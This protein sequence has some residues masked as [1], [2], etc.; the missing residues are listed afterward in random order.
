MESETTTS[1]EPSEGITLGEDSSGTDTSYHST[2]AGEESDTGTID[3]TYYTIDSGEVIS[4]VSSQQNEEEVIYISSD[5][6]SN[7]INVVPATQQ[8]PQV[9]VTTEVSSGINFNIPAPLQHL[10]LNENIEGT[11][12][13][14]NVDVIQKSNA[15]VNKNPEADTADQKEGVKDNIQHQLRTLLDPSTG[16]TL[17]GLN[18]VFEFYNELST[19]NV[20]TFHFLRFNSSKAK[21]DRY[22]GSWT[23]GIGV[24]MEEDFIEHFAQYGYTVSYS[25]LQEL[26]HHRKTGTASITFLVQGILERTIKELKDEKDSKSKKKRGQLNKALQKGIPIMTTTDPMQIH[27]NANDQWM[28]CIHV[29]PLLDSFYCSRQRDHEGHLISCPFAWLRIKEDNC[30]MTT[31]GYF[32]QILHVWKVVTTQ[33]NIITRVTRKS[34]Q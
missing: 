27:L 15:E 13:N 9:N 32:R 22:V 17:V 14:I 31:F 8:D 7:K 5:A 11:G 3:S 20:F 26:C 16:D 19:D 23:P 12:E 30:T 6:D 1:P 2:E 33:E 18:S 21:N 25:N 10:D 28:H 29:A 4:L 24:V 34:R